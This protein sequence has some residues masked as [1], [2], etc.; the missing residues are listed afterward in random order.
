LSS[1][2]P[3]PSRN[4]ISLGW[5]VGIA[6]V[7]MSAILPAFI[8]SWV[9]QQDSAEARLAAASRD[10]RVLASEAAREQAVRL[11]QAETWLAGLARLPAIA[12]GGPG[13]CEAALAGLG[14]APAWQRS[15]AVHGP[16]GALVCTDAP[17]GP[18]GAASASIGDRGYFQAAVGTRRFVVSDLVVGRGTPGHLVLGVLPVSGADGAIRRV[19]VA[20]I[21]AV[22]LGTPRPQAPPGTGPIFLVDSAAT[23]FAQLPAGPDLL[24]RSLVGTGLEAVQRGAGHVVGAGPD[25]VRR[26]YAF[27]PIPGTRASLVLGQDLAGAAD[28]PG[29]AALLPLAAAALAGLGL[30]LLVG[31]ALLTAPL[32]RLGRAAGLGAG[33][34]GLAALEAAVTDLTARLRLREAEAAALAASMARAESAGADATAALAAAGAARS[35]YALLLGQALRPAVESWQ[36]QLDQFTRD[37]LLGQ[38]QKQ[39]ILQLQAG[40][41]GML[42]AIQDAQDLAALEAGAV[43]LAPVP[44]RLASLVEACAEAVAP[45][46]QAKSLAFGTEIAPLLHPWVAADPHRLRQLLQQL[47]TQ[48]IRTTQRGEVVLRVAAVAEGMLCFEVSDSGNGLNAAGRDAL[49]RQLAEGAVEEPGPGLELSVVGALVRLMGGRID[50]ETAPGEGSIFRID[51]PLPPAVAGSPV[52]SRLLV[53]LGEPLRLLLADDVLSNREVARALLNGAGHSV[54]LVSDGAEAVQAALA[55]DWDAV[56]LDVHMPIMDGRTAARLI[57]EAG[58]RRGRVPILAITASATGAEVDDCLAAGMD[59]YLEKPLRAWELQNTLARLRG[60]AAARGAATEP[61]R[62]G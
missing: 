30:A 11:G 55:A 45:L 43:R 4:R 35:R 23:I 27:A 40:A 62:A 59:G 26:L 6:V 37:G 8:L 7:A 15:L 53:P 51:L 2:K 52:P 9:W 14:A 32:R 19:L 21:D 18:A 39:G 38:A 31:A 5:T 57:R 44:V 42:A 46:V 22:A 1:D 20:G 49:L 28:E 12:A 13:E 54:E 47:L 3:T 41:D 16:N 29:A 25:G 17:A 56:L 58:G 33:T 50:C 61:G 48:A 10:L 60:L 24:G 34:Q 36:V